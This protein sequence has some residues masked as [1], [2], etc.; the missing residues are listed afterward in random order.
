MKEIKIFP[1]PFELAEKFAEELVFMINDSGAA[2]KTFTLALSGGNTPKLIFSILSNHFSNSKS[3]EYVHFFWGD[4]RCVP[5]EDPDSNYGMAKKQLLEKIEIPFANIHRIFGEKDPYEEAVRY[6]NEIVG[7]TREMHGLPLFDMIILG[8][9]EDG[10][11]ASIFPDNMKL[12]DSDRICE[13]AV[14]PESFQKRITITGKVINN[15]EN[16]VFL[17]TGAKKAEVVAEII[18]KSKAG[19]YPAAL[20]EPRHG[21]LKWYLDISA[22][23][24][25]DKSKIG[26]QC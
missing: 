3:W 19:D 17:V 8:L 25:V 10:H 16:V 7:F 21:L 11:T 1:S 12:L 26:S 14:H 23:K 4:E 2:K 9:G 13:V 20:I 15:A 6:S 18:D 5:P 24:M 22:A